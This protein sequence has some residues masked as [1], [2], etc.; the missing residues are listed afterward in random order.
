[1]SNDQ[2]TETAGTATE[3]PAPARFPV[4]EPGSPAQQAVL[5]SVLRMLLTTE[6]G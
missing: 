1:M 6:P 3:A 4:L 2:D 5:A